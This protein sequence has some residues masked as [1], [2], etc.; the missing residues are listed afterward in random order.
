MRI[1]GY[2]EHPDCKITVFKTGTRYAI[3]VE[4]GLYEQTFK[5]REHVGIETFD[6]VKPL[7]T[8]PFIQSCMVRFNDMHQDLTSSIS[9]FLETDEDEFEEII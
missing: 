1:A 8:E 4:T 7:V 5:L 2:I 3:K 9:S 6:D